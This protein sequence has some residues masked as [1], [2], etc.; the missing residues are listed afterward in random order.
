[1]KKKK[2]KKREIYAIFQISC[3]PARSKINL[4]VSLGCAKNRTMRRKKK[5]A[6]VAEIRR[7]FINAIRIDTTCVSAF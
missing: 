7:K 1:M 2:E 4:S 5:N 6:I 3:L